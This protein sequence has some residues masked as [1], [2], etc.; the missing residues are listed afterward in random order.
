MAFETYASLAR[1]ATGACETRAGHAPLSSYLGQLPLGHFSAMAFLGPALRWP[2]AAGIDA[3]KILGPI[4]ARLPP[5]FSTLQPELLLSLGLSLACILL[6]AIAS[7]VLQSRKAITV[8]SRGYQ[9]QGTR[10]KSGNTLTALLL[11]P[12]GVGKTSL[13]SALAF[14]SVPSAHPSQHQSEST[15]SLSRNS[16]TS[17]SEEAQSIHLIDT[18]GHTRI[19]DAII[20]DHINDADIIVVCVDA[21]EALRGGAGTAKDVGLTEAVEYVAMYHKY[22]DAH[23]FQSSPSCS[24]PAG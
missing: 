8:Q 23:S 9:R 20:G 14:H 5:P 24:D 2:D 13:F 6:L 1:A 15:I 19:K 4:Q 12:S 16:L 17:L 22:A 18:P 11:G 21:K 3:N 7:T 10:V